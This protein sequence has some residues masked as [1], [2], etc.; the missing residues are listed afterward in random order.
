LLTLSRDCLSICMFSSG[1]P[2]PPISRSCF[3]PMGTPN[4]LWNLT[5]T[6]DHLGSEGDDLGS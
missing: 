4:L 6:T 5:W 3:N 2:G 1:L